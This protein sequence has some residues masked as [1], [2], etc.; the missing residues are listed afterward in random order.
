M[1]T[2]QDQQIIEEFNKSTRVSGNLDA[3]LAGIQGSSGDDK[4]GEGLF[5]K[6][7]NL[8]DADVN[9]TPLQLAASGSHE[10]KALF[11]IDEGS[12]FRSAAFQSAAQT[13][14]LHKMG[15]IA[16]PL[17]S[18][19]SVSTSNSNSPPHSSGG[20]RLRLSTNQSLAV[21]KYPALIELLGSPS[22]EK[23]VKTILADLNKIL[24]VKI[25]ENSKVIS[26]Y[27][28]V[29]ENDRQNIKQY[30][31]G[32]DNQWVC[33]VTASG[34]FRGDE[35]IYFDPE[36]DQASILRQ[37]GEDYENITGQFNIIHEMG[38]A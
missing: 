26:K 8:S 36:K 28:K 19:S 25:G 24:C 34:P 11:H 27:A 30:F 17:L 33:V 13:V 29:C 3:I 12:V 7:Y 20:V 37:D 14:G 32:D 4:D 38:S 6:K 35:A 18:S 2:K 15:A 16:D 31:A 9:A 21:Q 10:S 1:R 22:G 23:I 5:D